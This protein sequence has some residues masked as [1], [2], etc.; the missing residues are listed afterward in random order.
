[1]L[2]RFT[3]LGYANANPEFHPQQSDKHGFYK[4]EKRGRFY[5]AKYSK[6]NTTRTASIA[7]DIWWCQTVNSLHRSHRLRLRTPEIIDHG[8]DWY[9]A[10]WIEAT[11]SAEPTDPANKLDAYLGDYAK[12]LSAL[13]A[14]Q[15]EWVE[16]T[17]PSDDNSMPHSKLEDS[18]W[19]LWSEK[20]I[21]QG[22][23]SVGQLA[24]ARQLVGDYR[25]HL[26]PQLQHGDFVPWHIL[27]D[28]N[29]DWWL[30]DGEHASLQKP[31]Y[32]DLAY[33]YSRIFTRLH[34]PHHAATLLRSFEQFSGTPRQNIYPAL[35]PI[36]TSRAIG[37]HFDA[38]N[39]LH[40]DDY[41]AE[42]QDLLARCL[43]RE[44]AE[45]FNA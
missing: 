34:S 21:A 11:P 41:R 40:S 43:S 1:M 19:Q 13:D 12:C 27:I 36:M 42:A 30:I 17:P 29:Q 39:D 32:Y 18:S 37:M 15:P 44:P 3:Q 38:L 2:E 45:L 16:G 31:R 9:I 20:P 33:M 25:H 14:I 4:L 5:F 26:T 28:A 6:N 23:L 22:L 7:T 10:Q 8:K 24:Q 35:L